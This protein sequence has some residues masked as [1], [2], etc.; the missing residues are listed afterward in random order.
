M[1]STTATFASSDGCTP[2]AEP[3]RRAVETRTEQDGDQRDADHREH[4]PDHRRL[5]VV[6]VVDPHDDRHHR[7]AHAR[8]RQLLDEEEVGILELLQRHHRR[9]AV[10]HHDARTDEQQRRDEEQLVRFELSRHTPPIRLSPSPARSP[11]AGAGCRRQ[12]ELWS[13][14]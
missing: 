2:D 11:K 7:E 12:S 8:P 4:A 1:N 6:A 10:D 14:R 3:S 13:G 5:P 9:R